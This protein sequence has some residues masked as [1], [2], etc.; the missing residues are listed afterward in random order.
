MVGVIISLLVVAW[1]VYVMIGRKWRPQTVLFI[2]GLVLLSASILLH[3]GPLLAA[4]QSSGSAWLDLFKT[5]SD[6]MHNRAGGSGMDIMAITGFGAYMEYV[7]AS[8]ALFDVV[9]APLKRM[10][11]PKVVLVASFLVTQILVIFI[12]SH[13]GLGLLL[14]ATMYPVLIR[15]GVSRMSAL[16]VIACCQFIDHGPGSQAEIFASQVTNLHPAT[17]FVQYQLPIT[18]PIIFAVAITHYFVQPWF[19][20]RERFVPDKEMA[21]LVKDQEGDRTPLIYAFLPVFPVAFIVGFS[22]LFSKIITVDV[23]TAMVLSTAIS[24]VFEYFRRRDA[25]EV[26]ESLMN[27]FKG[28]GYSFT[29]V[30]SLIIAGETFAAG[31]TKIGAIDTLIQSAQSAGLGV[32][33]LIIIMSLLM[34]VSAFLMGSGNATFFSFAPIAPKVAQYLQVETV[35]LLLPMQIM[36]SFGRVVCPIAAPIVAIAGVAG[37]S[38][39]KV[40]QRTAIPMMVA[41]TLNIVLNFAIFVH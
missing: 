4:K 31:L 23:S 5:I 17:Y 34:A 18:L 39:F 9:G 35:T 12:P 29:N 36:T 6:I 33:S 27:F 19:D 8:R 14:M 30:I 15:L 38:P 3:G 41:A 20:R 32:H 24:L 10:N 26:V 1:L 16:A 37:V 25:K 22:P 11:S 21:A 13:S 28:M 40:V 7:G 2:A